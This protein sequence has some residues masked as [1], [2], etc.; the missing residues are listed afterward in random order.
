VTL[1]NTAPNSDVLQAS[2]CP[3]FW[4]NRSHLQHRNFSSGADEGGIQG[5]NSFVS[6]RLSDTIGNGLVQVILDFAT[7]LIAGATWPTEMGRN[8][9]DASWQDFGPV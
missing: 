8:F 9:L 4:H 7:S 6:Q 5:E 1:N 3:A 2:G